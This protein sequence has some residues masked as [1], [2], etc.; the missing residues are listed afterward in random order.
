MTKTS[1]TSH[2]KVKEIKQDVALYY[3]AAKKFPDL[4]EEEAVEG[5][6][7][8]WKNFTVPEDHAARWPAFDAS[9]RC[10][11]PSRR[12]PALLWTALGLHAPRR[13][14]PSRG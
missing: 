1:K 4:D 14:G 8:L 11:V 10:D 5:A 12:V 7:E 2:L 9:L 3:I 6:I 13:E